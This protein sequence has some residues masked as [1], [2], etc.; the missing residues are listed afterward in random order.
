MKRE[1]YVGD[2]ISYERTKL[3]QDLGH[4]IGIMLLAESLYALI[5]DTANIS[6]LVTMWLIARL[7]IAFIR[8]SMIV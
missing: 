4:C 6:G 5:S 8:V 7:L 1:I 3:R 2:L